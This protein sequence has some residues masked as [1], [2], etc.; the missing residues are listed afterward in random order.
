MS[1]A[2]GTPAPAWWVTSQSSA[3]QLGLGGK[4][5]QGYN[6]T[7]STAQGHNGTVFV[8]NSQY[9]NP[10]LAKQVIGNAAAALDTVGSLTADS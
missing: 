4:F 1:T 6:V 2:L 10:E 8:P 7:F 5:E 9:Q 3:T